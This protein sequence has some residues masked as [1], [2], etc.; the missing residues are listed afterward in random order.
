MRLLPGISVVLL[1]AGFCGGLFGLRTSAR[2]YGEW[3]SPGVNPYQSTEKAEFSWS[4]LRY[5]SRVSRFGRGF[6][7][8]YGYGWGGGSWSRDYPK[9]DRQ[10]LLAMKRLTRINGRSTEQVVDLDSDEIDNYPWVYAVQVENWTF[11]DSEAKR[12]REYLRKGGFL[13]VDDFHGTED[14]E[15]FMEGMRMVFPNR[16]VEDLDN[17]DE[18]F[19]TLYDLDDRF[20][21]PG[22]QYINT[23]RTYEKDGYVPKWRAIRDDKGRIV[24]AICHNMHLGDAWEW[25]DSPEYP[26][27]FASMAFRIG[28]DYII[29]GM[30]H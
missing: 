16:P 2:Q 4:R 20:Q 11:S 17:K 19:H 8:G 12:L 5:T 13:M 24:V 23:G 26:E 6:G 22:E 28:L 1:L 27:R 29:Y 9:A 21:V 18:I 10:F 7:Y 25:A 30:T 3:T 15:T 14:W